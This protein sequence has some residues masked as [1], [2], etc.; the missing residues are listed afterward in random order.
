MVF[1]FLLGDLTVESGGPP[2]CVSDLASALADR[3][4]EV[5]I[6][7][8]EKKTV[9]PEI[10]PDNE[11][12]CIK[13][14]KWI[15][16]PGLNL[17]YPVGLKGLLRKAQFNPETF[18]HNNLLWS[19]GNINLKKVLDSR[20]GRLI[21]CPHGN[22]TR[23]CYNSKGW[24]K[25]PFWNLLGRKLYKLSDFIHATS[26]EE[27]EDLRLLNVVS[28]IAII[29]NATDIPAVEKI[30]KHNSSDEEKRILFLSRISK[31]KGLELLLNT[32][33]FVKKEGWKLIIAGTDSENYKKT[34]LDLVNQLNIANTVEFI[35]GVAGARREEVFAKADLFILPT[36][37]EN[38]G[39]AI[40]EALAR[41]VPVITTK[42]AP[43]G[44][45]ENYKC[46]WW[47]DIDADSIASALKDG[48][49]LSNQE[50]RTMGLRGRE[51]IIKKHSWNSAAENM[52][53]CCRWVL[54]KGEKPDFLYTI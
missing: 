41:G 1:L 30:A 4:H 44:D 8:G 33:S 2:R 39:L 51:L 7:A 19:L 37:S 46:G 27:K 10:R 34:L 5:S 45:I 18:V 11:K 43:W 3:G 13:R 6:Y 36:F 38:Y 32:W 16:F 35:G 29:R 42:G 25:K 31:K 17:S 48:M 26:S 23:W 21:C 40:A 52:E 50:R 49:N 28:P 54:K 53:R 47:C 22:L 24:K 12:V 14:F 9:F 15:R 20:G